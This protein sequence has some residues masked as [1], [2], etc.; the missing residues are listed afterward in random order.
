MSAVERAPS[1]WL[2]PALLTYIAGVG[3]TIGTVL[4]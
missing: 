3:A 1:R 2:L 4:L